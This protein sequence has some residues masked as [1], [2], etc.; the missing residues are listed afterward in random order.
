MEEAA[1]LPSCCAENEAV[2][3][4]PPRASRTFAMRGGQASLPPAQVAT[5]GRHPLLLPWLLFFLSFPPKSTHSHVHVHLYTYALVHT[6]LFFSHPSRDQG[7]PLCQGAVRRAQFLSDAPRGWGGGWGLGG[8]CY[9]FPEGL[10]FSFCLKQVL[11]SW[12]TCWGLR[13]VRATLLC[14]KNTL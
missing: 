11:E 1:S 6:C 12:E 10:E 3:V 13:Q 4:L 2:K 7:Q 8:A 14:S 5:R 9:T